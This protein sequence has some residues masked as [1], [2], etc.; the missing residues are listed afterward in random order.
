MLVGDLGLSTHRDRL[1]GFRKAMQ[2]AHL[3]IRD[4]F[5][6]AGD[7]EV[8]NG[9][10]DSLRVLSLPIT[11]TAIMVCNNKLLLGLLQA[12][13]ERKISIPKDVSVLGFDDY[14]W[15]KYFNPSLTAIAQSTFEMGRRAFEL[16]LQII[17][18]EKNIGSAERRI[19][20][21]AELRVRNSTAPIEYSTKA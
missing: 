16:L 15:N 12:L 17:N 13:D 3:A 20:L 2:E 5:L 18:K 8:A 14:A 4:D 9:F 6:I 1:E 19:R 7:L 10:E 11:P 21:N